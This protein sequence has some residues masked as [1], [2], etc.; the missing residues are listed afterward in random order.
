MFVIDGWLW[1][2]QLFVSQRWSVNLIVNE[3]PLVMEEKKEKLIFTV[4]INFFILMKKSLCFSFSERSKV[5]HKA[6]VIKASI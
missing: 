3:K 5:S 2:N 4:G 6:F 1:V